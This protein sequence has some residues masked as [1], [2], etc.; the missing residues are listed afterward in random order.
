[1]NIE[2]NFFDEK[3]FLP[4]YKAK[5][6]V[7][8][9]NQIMNRFNISPAELCELKLKYTDD[10]GDRVTIT[11]EEDF[12]FALQIKKELKIDIDIK[13]GT[14]LYQSLFPKE[15]S[16]VDLL[17]KE[18]EAK[19]KELQEILKK[20]AMER[21]RK[22]K[23]AEEERK[24]AEELEKIK[25]AEEERKR[26]EAENKYKAEID[27]QNERLRI[28]A[29]EEKLR[30]Q[31][32]KKEAD[33]KFLVSKLFEKEFE[34]EKEKLLISV[35]ERVLAQLN[36]ESPKVHTSVTCDGCGVY[37]IT[38]IRYKCTECRNFDYCST[39]E[40]KIK[41][42]HNFIKIKEP[43]S[44]HGFQKFR[45]GCKRKKEE[46]FL[47][48]TKDILNKVFPNIQFDLADDQVQKPIEEKP[49]EIRIENK[50]KIEEVYELQ[51]KEI[52]DVLNLSIPFEELSKTLQENQGNIDSALSCIFKAK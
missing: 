19:E 31:K 15:E 17:K 22:L 42:P 27:S 36:N 5:S 49:E 50:E 46:K 14:Q 37:P 33:V 16:A 39:C 6:L 25:L 4:A 48:K 12:K 43:I 44:Y 18:I 8:F 30:E 11:N 1:M 47:E 7:D 45:G 13:E 41:H 29:E 3:I 28:E 9:H 34:R 23:E 21:Q 10:E 38:G 52:L 24:A 32:M 20:E 35:T 2:I 51:A 40:E 26:I